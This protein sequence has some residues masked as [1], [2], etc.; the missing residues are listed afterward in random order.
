MDLTK[1][2]VNL[3]CVVVQLDEMIHLLERTAASKSK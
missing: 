1:I 2:I 3:R